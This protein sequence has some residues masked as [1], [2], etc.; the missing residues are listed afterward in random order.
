[1]PT[2][3]PMCNAPLQTRAGRLALAAVAVLAAGAASAQVPQGVLGQT[4]GRQA[5]SGGYYVNALPNEPTIRVA[6]RGD[7]PRT[8]IYDLGR[9]FDTLE[10]VVALAG[11]PAA[12]DLDP[13]DPTV[14]VR[15]F[16]GDGP[17][18][19]TVYESA[20]EALAGGESPAPPLRG[21]D[22]VE[23]E[24]R[25]ERGVYVWGAVGRP[26]YFEVG[27]NVDA[28]R[29]LAL[30]GGPQ[31]TGAR[32]D[33]VINDATVSIV[34]PGVGAIYQAPLEEFVVGTNVPTLA[35]GD[36]LQVEVVRR[37]RTT[38]REVISTIG[39]VATLVLVGLRLSEEL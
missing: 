8:G 27:P 21:G 12:G 30:A 33:E 20:Y 9:G 17:A 16:R 35:D 14:V 34:R 4:D 28:V 1:M 18:R 25:F 11:G 37:N 6:V 3:P 26:G 23:V 39:A 2:A 7:V 10:S 24:T 31:G 36:A 15:V 5:T 29:L 22:V 38:F 32:G 13:R 19:R